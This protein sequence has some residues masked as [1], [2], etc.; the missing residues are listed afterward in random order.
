MYL[1]KQGG[2]FLGRHVSFERYLLSSETDY[3]Y[4]FSFRHVLGAEFYADWYTLCIGI[5]I[6][7]FIGI[8]CILYYS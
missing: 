4:Y 6:R 5:R 7:I 2:E 1:I 3:G 8:G